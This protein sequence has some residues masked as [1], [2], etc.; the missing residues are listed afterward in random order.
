MKF[1]NLKTA[2]STIALLRDPYRYIS[3]RA[4]EV[5]ED[6]FETRLLCGLPPA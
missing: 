5:G 4:A 2:D 6:L 1:S 3:R